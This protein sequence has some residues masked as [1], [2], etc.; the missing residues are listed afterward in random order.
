VLDLAKLREGKLALQ[1]VM[2]SWSDDTSEAYQYLLSSY[3]VR[4]GVKQVQHF[5]LRLCHGACNRPTCPSWCR[6]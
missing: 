6:S 5:S 1:P 2:V 3:C 4:V